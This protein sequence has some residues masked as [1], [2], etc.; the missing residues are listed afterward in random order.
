M[1]DREASGATAGGRSG[2]GPILLFIVLSLVAGLIGGYASRPGPWYDALNKP[3]WT[4]PKFVFAPV[5]IGLYILMGLAM[6]LAWNRRTRRRP[7]MVGVVTL[8]LGQL[9]F[10]AGWSWL[11]FGLHRP[12]VA[13]V[14][15]VLLFILVLLLFFKFMRIRPVSALLIVP[16]LGWLVFAGALNFVIWVKNMPPVS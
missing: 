15:M 6:G 9:V 7:M 13:F 4:P 11:F 16:Y 10:N 8:F 14:E 2:W 1:S 5:W 3:S 12:D